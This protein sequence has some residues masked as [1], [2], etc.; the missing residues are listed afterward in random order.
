MMRFNFKAAVIAVLAAV[1]AVAIVSCSSEIDLT[2]GLDTTVTWGGEAF[3][4]PIGS[5]AEIAVG[6]FLELSEGDIIRTDED[7]NY[8]LEFSESFSQT[9]SMTQ[10]TS[11]LTVPGFA[12]SFEPR[13]VRL[14]D[15]GD[16]PE[17]TP[18]VDVPEDVPGED[19]PGIIVD[20]DK[21]GVNMGFEEEF[22]YEFGFEEAKDEGLESIDRVDLSETFLRPK[23][24]LSGLDE[25]PASMEVRVTVEVPEHYVFEESP[26]VDPEAGTVTFTG[27]MN[28]EGVVEFTPVTLVA[29]EF[30]PGDDAMQDFVFTDTFAVS[31]SVLM[32]SREDLEGV[33]GG[34]M[35]AALTIIAGSDDG[36][37]RPESFRGKVDID[38]DPVNESLVLTG[39]PDMLK[40]EDASLDFYNPRLT[41][42]VSTNANVPVDMHAQ[43]I[44]VFPTG[45][46]DEVSLDLEAPVSPDPDVIETA[47]FW[48]SSDDPAGNPDAAGYEWV[49]A[50]V[51]GLLTR[52]PDEVRVNITA[53]TD[54][55]ES[56]YVVC[57]EEYTVDGEFAFNV[58]FSF[59]DS[60]RFAVRDTI[61]GMPEILS[62][63][64]RSANVQI[65]GTVTT[66]IPVNVN[67]KAYFLDSYMNRIEMPV[68]TQLINGTASAGTPQET[69]LELNVPQTDIRND[70]SYLVFEFQLL[71]GQ[72]PG[73]PLSE[74]SS[75]QAD[76]ILNVPGGVTVDFNDLNF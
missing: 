24:E 72:T 6:D 55:T 23:I 53:G 51:R 16:I 61:E 36:N 41:A 67:L 43:I 30:E 7:G 65:A 42:R 73:I 47:L 34:V 38:V 46:G 20:G 44:P 28:D 11:R 76:I 49:E 48:I 31:Q 74:D 4:L 75:I 35:E 68:I 29:I 22:I 14:P 71:S 3:S 40:S 21:V 25:L 32:V 12:H 37:L 13:P 66:T 33:S 26:M 64:V 18:D 1:S 70:I 39:I 58:P 63:M 50:D 54:P 19:I 27:V 52:I 45:D 2:D 60:L 10:F 17:N 56:A 5:T 59:G 8:Y 69:P 62:T 15:V 9:I 57:D